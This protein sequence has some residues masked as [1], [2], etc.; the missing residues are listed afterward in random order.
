ML[1]GTDWRVG[2]SPLRF[3]GIFL[4]IKP[5]ASQVVRGSTKQPAFMKKEGSEMRHEI[6]LRPYKIAWDAP[7]DEGG[8]NIL[9]YQ[10]RFITNR[11]TTDWLDLE[12]T[13]TRLLALLPED[14]VQEVE[15]RALNAIG[16]GE[17]VSVQVKPMG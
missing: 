6:Q 9:D 14:V 13:D 12:S 2:S 3:V 5:L 17:V 10:I 7:T 4:M 1:N 11:G 15:V 8:S 16:P